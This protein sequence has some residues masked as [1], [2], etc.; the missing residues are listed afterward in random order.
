MNKTKTERNPGR[1]RELCTPYAN[2]EE[3]AKQLE[4]FAEEMLTLRI[5]YKIAD[6]YVV[7]S[8]SVLNS[9]GEEGEIITC[10]HFGN[11]LKAEMLAAY[12]LGHEQS[13]RQEK[14]AAILSQA[15]KRGRRED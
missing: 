10:S 4:A 11:E 5:K 7:I 3:A 9:D 8:S 15:V 14:I 2:R 13:L 6:L 1:Y 12:A